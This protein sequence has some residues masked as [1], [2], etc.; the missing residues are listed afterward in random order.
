MKRMIYVVW[1]R[2]S[3]VEGREQEAWFTSIKNI[4]SDPTAALRHKKHLLGRSV[5]A[6]EVEIHEVVLSPPSVEV[7]VEEEEEGN[8]P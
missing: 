6:R 7:E 3:A 2:P 5:I 8:E 4:F 1:N